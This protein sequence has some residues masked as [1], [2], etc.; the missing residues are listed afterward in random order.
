MLC[1]PVSVEAFATS[2][3]LIHRSLT[4][5]QIRLRN[6][7]MEARDLHGPE[8]S[9][10]DYKMLRI[11]TL[12]VTI[13]SRDLTNFSHTVLLSIFPIYLHFY[14]SLFFASQFLCH[15]IASQIKHVKKTISHRPTSTVDGLHYTQVWNNHLSLP[16]L[17]T[18][19][20]H[21]F[22]QPS[23]RHLNPCSNL[24]SAIHFYRELS[25][26]TKVFKWPLPFKISTKISRG[27]SK[28]GKL[29]FQQQVL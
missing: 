14:T 25:S 11:I 22:A 12:C 28:H 13:S 10:D 6:T 1:C 7:V 4:T 18:D 19:F 23:L 3:S 21:C 5:C 9:T 8:K 15:H 27:K 20:P 17:S 26:T 2:W 29:L 16:E 24:T